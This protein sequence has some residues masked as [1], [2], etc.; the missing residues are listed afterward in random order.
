[1]RMLPEDP[2]FHAKWLLTICAA[3][4]I[5]FLFAIAMASC[6]TNRPSALPEEHVSGAELPTER[7]H[8]TQLGEAQAQRPDHV[9]RPDEEQAAPR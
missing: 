7:D 3:F 1:M 8:E 6:T 9:V 4:G 5:A 2:S